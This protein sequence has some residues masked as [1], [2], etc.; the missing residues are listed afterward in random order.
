[1]ACSACIRSCGRDRLAVGSRTLLKRRSAGH[2]EGGRGA[3]AAF[4]QL[5]HRTTRRLVV[6]DAGSRYYELAKP[7]FE[8]LDEAEQIV[9][10][11]ATG[12]AGRLRV[13]APVTFGRLHV[14]PALGSFLD[15][16]PKM[17][18]DFMLDD[19]PIDIVEQQVDVSL[20]LGTLRQSS[21]VVRRVASAPRL[22]LASPAY[23]ARRG[24]PLTP[25]DLLGHEVVV[26]TQPG[27]GPKWIFR[28][29]SGNT[30]VQVSERLSISGAEGVR[31]AVLAGLGLTIASRW[32]FA[33]ELASGEVLR[34]LGQ[35]ELDAMDLWAVLPNR[36]APARAR[37]FLD[38]IQ[39]ILGRQHEVDAR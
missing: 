29:G 18:L 38:F 5:L 3:R 19:R 12:I 24:T 35:Y 22:V 15:A 6:T 10:G 32:M 39:R 21:F 33:P 36:R 34:V 1:M 20:Q 17:Q 7:A 2:F 4:G 27:G 14:V 31:A 37:L 8:S 28:H 11:Q 23:L 30:S 25:G 16:H 13:A 26:Y 9:R